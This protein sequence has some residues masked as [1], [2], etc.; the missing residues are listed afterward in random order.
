MPLI[1]VLGRQKQESNHKSEVIPVFIVT[2]QLARTVQWNPVSEQQQRSRVV[3]AVVVVAV[4]HLVPRQEIIVSP[5]Q[6]G[7]HSVILSKRPGTRRQ[8]LT[9]LFSLTQT[10]ALKVASYRFTP[11]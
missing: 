11:P 6:P 7:M 4:R 2:S 8:D 10:P 5:G 9:V 1:P 3:V